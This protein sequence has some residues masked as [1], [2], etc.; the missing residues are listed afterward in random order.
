MARPFTN[1]QTRVVWAW[2]DPLPTRLK[3][4]WKKCTDPMVGGARSITLYDGCTPSSGTHLHVLPLCMLYV[5]W[6]TEICWCISGGREYLL[7]PWAEGS[8]HATDR[9]GYTY[10]HTLQMNISRGHRAKEIFKPRV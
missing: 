10:V 8:I 6:Y 5:V 2:P 4:G 7:K 1:A 3:K 9:P